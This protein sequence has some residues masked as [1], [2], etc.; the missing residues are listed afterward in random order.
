MKI[1]INKWGNS[2]GIRI[3]K[4][5]AEKANLVAGNEMQIKLDKNGSLIIKTEET[6]TLDDLIEGV[7]PEN[8]QPLMITNEVGKEKW[9]Y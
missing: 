7:N 3:P 8:R 2:L 9:E 1:T 6:L 5:I 4:A